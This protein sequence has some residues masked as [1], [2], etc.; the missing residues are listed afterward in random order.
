MLRFVKGTL[1]YGI[2]FAWYASD[3]VKEDGPLRI[4]AY[5]DSSFADDIDTGRTT[6]GYVIKVNGA[7][8]SAFNKLS[9]RV[10]SCVNHSELR[11]FDTALSAATKDNDDPTDSTS[12]AFGK[13]SRNIAWVR[14]IKA[15]L[16]GRAI[17]TITP[18]VEDRSSRQVSETGKGENWIVLDW[19]TQVTGMESNGMESRSLPNSTGLRT[20]CYVRCYARCYSMPGTAPSHSPTCPMMPSRIT[21]N[22]WQ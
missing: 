5:S 10:D 13:T 6:L 1:H 22:N 15:A 8:I 7:T 18:T 20:E 14:G 17:D 12:V 4:E 16:E 9:Q 21:A 19:F 2:E 3:S 11:A